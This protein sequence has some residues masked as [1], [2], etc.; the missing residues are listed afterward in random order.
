MKK[1]KNQHFILGQNS[2]LLNRFSVKTGIKRSLMI[3]KNPNKRF[4]KRYKILIQRNICKNSRNLH[5]NMFVVY[6][7]FQRLDVRIE[8]YKRI[9][10]GRRFSNINF[11]FNICTRFLPKHAVTQDRQPH[12]HPLASAD[13]FLQ[14]STLHANKLCFVRHFQYVIVV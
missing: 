3:C 4:P 2:F 9:H 1:K 14:L 5:I 8:S 11:F 10:L 12:T 7:R 6:L 13:S